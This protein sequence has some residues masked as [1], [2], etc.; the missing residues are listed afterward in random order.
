MEKFVQTAAGES[1]EDIHKHAAATLQTIVSKLADR[2]ALAKPAERVPILNLLSLLVTTIG[3]LVAVYYGQ[4]T[5]DA[6]DSS[7]HEAAEL[8]AVNARASETQ[9]EEL[10]RLRASTDRLIQ[11]ITS[12]DEDDATDLWV[13]QRT[14]RVTSRKG[15]KAPK[16]V[17]LYPNQVVSV[18]RLEGKWGRIEYYDYVTDTSR[19][20]WILK[21]YMRRLSPDG[22]PASRSRP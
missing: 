5:K 7:S 15:P 3:V 11:N 6:G 4:V 20:G 1:A 21:K 12:A 16:L 2:L 8:R 10:K 9:V 17:T 19:T 13:I 18:V 22:R 14:A